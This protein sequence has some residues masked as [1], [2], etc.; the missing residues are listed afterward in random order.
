MR[1]NA[2]KTAKTRCCPTKQT[3]KAATAP[4]KLLGSLGRA[5]FLKKGVQKAQK[6]HLNITPLGARGLC[7]QVRFIRLFLLS[8]ICVLNFFVGFVGRIFVSN[9]T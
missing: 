2:T 4:K 5:T 6:Q 7:T 8:V 1:T 3:H 9:I